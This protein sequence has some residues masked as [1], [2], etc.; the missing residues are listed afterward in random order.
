MSRALIV[1]RSKADRE[2]AARWA[3]Q[4]PPGSRIEFKAP[5]RTLPQNDR[6]WAM[7]TD[8]SRQKTHAGRR[9]PPFI[10]KTLMMQAMGRHV[11]WLPTLDGEG[12]VPLMYSS[13]D[14][15]TEEMTEL[16]DF[17]SAWGAQNGVRFHDDEQVEAAE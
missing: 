17:M 7:L 11:Q 15:S 2:R 10:W 6:F 12:A 1:I 14:L 5:R 3:A 4:V 16:M 9:L 8:I 13:S